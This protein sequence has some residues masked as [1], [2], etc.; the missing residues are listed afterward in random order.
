M[1]K[2]K[3]S[4]PVVLQAGALVCRAGKQGIE[5][6]LVRSKKTPDAW[7]FPKGHLER[8]ETL[9]DAALREAHEECGVAGVIVGPVGQRL[10]FQS[11]RESVYVQ[12]FLLYARTETTSPEGRQKQWFPIDGALSQLTHEDARK[13]LRV[14]RPEIEW[15]IEPAKRGASDSEAFA[16]HMEAEFEHLAASLI[17]NEE[18]GEKRVNVFIAVCGGVGT[19]LGFLV[20]KDAAFDVEKQIAVI[21]AL[22]VLLLLGYG[23]LLRVVSRN[24]ASDQY[25]RKLN[26]VRQY[27]LHGPDDV[28]RYVLP[29]GP[30]EPR[31]RPSASHRGLGRGGWFETMA[32][33][34]AVVAGAL[35]AMIMWTAMHL[36][37][38]TRLWGHTIST[39]IAGIAGVAVGYVAWR[40]LIA[41]GNALLTQ[42][43]R[44]TAPERVGYA[45]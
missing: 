18:S 38:E 3:D 28:R 44:K 2:T 17:S 39:M 43:A 9:E 31:S 34:E 41:R 22:S 29:F 26:R 4:P 30:F 25:K 40:I 33:L 23:T 32:L 45:P 37:N 8:H 36:P 12:Y 6:L 13:L 10:K 42:E 20:G 14:V 11:G 21:V 27:F 35:G 5:L 19:A 7:V 15:W 1:M 24:A 16:A